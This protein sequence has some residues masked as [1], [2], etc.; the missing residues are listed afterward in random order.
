MT[1]EEQ[2]GLILASQPLGKESLAK[3]KKAIKRAQSSKSKIKP[4]L[5]V[6]EMADA[7][8]ASGFLTWQARFGCLWYLVM[9]V[10]IMMVMVMVV[11]MV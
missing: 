9:V 6:A 4:T 1:L 10:A 7:R 5:A 11:A 3:Q 2:Q 8:E